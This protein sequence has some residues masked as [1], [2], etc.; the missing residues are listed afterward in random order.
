MSAEPE[1]KSLVLTGKL[2][3]GMFVTELD[4]PWLETP[5]LIQG[6]L[7]ADNDEITLLRRYCRSVKIDRTRS[8]GEQY[9]AKVPHE[10]DTRL[11]GTALPSR[12][13]AVS[14]KLDFLSIARKLRDKPIIQREIA[15]P[16]LIMRDGQSDLASEL[17]Y[18]APVIADVHKTLQN[19]QAA[20]DNNAAVDLNQAGGLVVEM[21]AGVERN[22]DAMLWLTRL[23]KTDQYSYDHAVD[24]SVNL[25]IFGRF[26]GLTGKTVEHLGLAGLMQDIGKVML[27]PELLARPSVLSKEEYELTKSHVASSLELLVGQ[28]DFPVEVLMLVA[29]HHERRDGSGYPRQISGE[30][31]KFP[32]E[33]TGLI[34]TYCA[35]TRHRAYSAPVSNQT[36]LES[37]IKLRG[38]KFRET[39]IDQFIQ[40]VGLYPI[41]TLLELNT[42]EV[43]VVIQQNQ[44]RRL[45]PKLLIL[46]AEDKSIERRPRNLDLILD[47]LTPTGQ[48]Y[49][50]R[51]ALPTNAYG[52]DW[53]EFFLD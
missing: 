50:I 6:F 20:I 9:A 7:I 38:S 44:V 10:R 14:Q 28:R 11:R 32:A 31:L 52:I 3:I 4:R 49:R 30:K 22:P 19:I 1:S 42:G 25:M 29:A 45:K 23:R 24:V 46:T 43:A 26:L 53:S 33:L 18:S 34:D 47:P 12:I 37:L 5:F 21:A 51:H 41:G 48:P 40:C 39:L 16:P 13:S 27:D 8:I 2:K 17:L 36:A 15:P 35:M